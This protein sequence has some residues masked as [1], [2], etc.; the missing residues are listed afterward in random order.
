MEE[1]VANKNGHYAFESAFGRFFVNLTIIMPVYR[2]S[3]LLDW[4]LAN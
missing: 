2:W 3:D 1:R 4:E